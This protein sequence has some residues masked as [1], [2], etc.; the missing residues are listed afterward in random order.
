MHAHPPSRPRRRWPWLL[1]LGALV[2]L[3]LLLLRRGEEAPVDVAPSGVPPASARRTPAP[4]PSGEVVPGAPAGATSPPSPALPPFTGRVLSSADGRPVA[5]AEVTFFAPEGATS[6]RTEP[7]G[8]FRLVPSRP[9]PHQ[10][11]AVNADG[12]VPFGP[13]W[14]QSPVRLL[15]PAP[16]GTPELVVSLDPEVRV[17][18]RVEAA[19]GGAPIAG[20]QVGLRVPGTEPGILGGEGQWTTDGRGEFSGA[21]P[22]ESV[23]VARAAGFL[24]AA[25]GLRG[26][27]RAQTVTLR[28]RAAPQDAAAERSLA[29]RVVDGDGAA[30]PDAVVTLGAG[31]GRGRGA[32]VPLPA[33]VTSDAQGR[34][35]FEAVPAQLGWAQAQA[36]DQLSDRTAVE[37]G[38]AELVLTVRPGGVLAGRVVHADGQPATA[39]A[40]QLVRLRR[41]DPGRTLSIVDPEGRFE[42]RGL[43]SGAWELQAL[44]ADSGPSDH[45]RVELPASPGARV[46]KELR[47]HAG[48]HLGGVVRDGNTRAPVAGAR[49]AL[50]A[51]PG[52]DSVVVRT[53]TFTGP[54]GRFTLEGVP[55]TPV[56]VTVEADRYN[57]RI[58]TL[59]RGRTEVEV[60]LRP[61]ATDQAPTTDLVGIGAV[62]TRADDGIALGDMV[63]SGGAAAA[64]LHPGDVVLRIDGQPVTE[65]GFADAIQRLRG[66]EGTVVRLDVRRADGTTTT[67]DVLRRPISF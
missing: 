1:G 67:I 37:P 3:V 45:V 11:A 16:P 65:L 30:V 31:R 56:S 9:G 22:P 36:G 64:G 61:L 47:L 57:R 33:P 35:R 49:V 43:A 60:S 54:D 19:D 4:V 14:G 52:E 42:V 38:E 39:F 40:L 10:L 25:E 27:A 21:V 55:D 44:A 50:E 34:F 24:S 32:A 51:S 58:V 17:Q 6:V 7:D 20:A 41:A 59:P 66:E 53:G 29:G 15:A 12:F 48:R 46:E 63:A 26:A 2:A 18:G 13:E 5:G 28:L 62:V 8:R 23:F